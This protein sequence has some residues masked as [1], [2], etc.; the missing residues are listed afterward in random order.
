MKKKL[1]SALM[2][3]AL[4]ATC[5][6]GC[7]SKKGG[8]EGGSTGEATTE[9]STEEPVVTNLYGDGN[10]NYYG[11]PFHVGATVMYWNMKAL[12][13]AGIK[14]EDVKAVKTWDQYSQCYLPYYLI[15][16]L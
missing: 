14:E 3:T 2:C 12:E 5:V 8:S 1:V 4:L 9:T 11:A 10:G 13:E 6:A 16:I 7:G 15:V